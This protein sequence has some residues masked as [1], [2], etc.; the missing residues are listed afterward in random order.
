MSNRIERRFELTKYSHWVAAT[1]ALDSFYIPFR[2]RFLDPGSRFWHG[3]VLPD[4]WGMAI[5]YARI[6]IF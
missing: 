5:P 1:Y 3:K 4:V 6:L 2:L